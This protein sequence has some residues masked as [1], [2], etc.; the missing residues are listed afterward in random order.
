[1]GILRSR[2][3]KQGQEEERRGERGGER[4]PA[5]EVVPHG[6][7]PRPAV[8]PNPPRN[9][10][11]QAK[12]MIVKVKAMKIVPDHAAL[13]L[14]RRGEPGQA[15]GQLD[16]VHAEQAQGEEDEQRRPAR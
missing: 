6:A 1:M 10:A 14:P 2:A 4:Q 11:T 13:S 8:P 16:L 9:G 3:G 12:L 5:E 7:V 15:A